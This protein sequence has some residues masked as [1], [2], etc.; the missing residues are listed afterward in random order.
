MEH[1]GFL[2]RG[3]EEFLAAGADDGGEEIDGEGRVAG[4]KDVEEASNVTLGRN[5]VRVHGQRTREGEERL[6]SREVPPQGWV[7]P[8]EDIWNESELGDGGGEGGQHEVADAEDR[9]A[10]EAGK[11]QVRGQGE[12]EDLGDV[13]VPLEVREIRVSAKEG[14]D[15]GIKE[16]LVVVELSFGLI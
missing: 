11:V 13:M 4:E 15:E 2:G 3:L 10:G 16:V 8:P 6:R 5:V 12:E 1:L 14:D 9:K 7:G